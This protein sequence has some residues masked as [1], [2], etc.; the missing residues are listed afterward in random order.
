MVTLRNYL[1]F[2]S[3][4]LVGCSSPQYPKYSSEQ[5][6]SRN[7]SGL[8]S[9][10]ENLRYLFREGQLPTKRKDALAAGVDRD[11]VLGHH[12]EG[13]FTVGRNVNHYSALLRNSGSGSTGSFKPFFE[14]LYVKPDTHWLDAGGGEGYATKMAIDLPDSK[15][16]TTLISVE[17]NAEDIIDGDVL[18]R[19]VFK[20]RF[21][22]DIGD[23]ELAASDLV[24]DVYGPIAYSSRPDIV[25]EKYLHNLKNDGV[26]YL[27]LGEE[28]DMF[29]KYNQIITSRGEVLDF[30]DWLK[31]INGTE[32][33]I[34]TTR[35][36]P[37][38]S[39]VLSGEK[40]RTARMH[41]D[42]SEIQ[43]PKL[44][45]IG[46]KEGSGV[47]GF[48]VP[49]TVFVEEGESS[50]LIYP[51]NH[52]MIPDIEGILKQ[53]NR[54]NGSNTL[55][56]EVDRLKSSES[57]ANF[58]GFEL[59]FK[60]FEESHLTRLSDKNKAKVVKLATNDFRAGVT[61]LGELNG[62]KNLKLIT[63]LNGSF[64]SEET[65]DVVLKQYI[66]ALDDDGVIILGLGRQFGGLGE[67]QVIDH[68][69]NSSLLRYWME[70]IEGLNVKIASFQQTEVVTGK[71]LNVSPDAIE[72]NYDGPLVEF[73]EEQSFFSEY[74]VLKIKN[75]NKVK[76]PK[77]EYLG[78]KP[79]NE[80]G[81]EMPFYRQIQE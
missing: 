7:P 17:T 67:G 81:I 72:V 31:T 27:H 8:F 19:K 68:V 35:L 28:K 45:R 77:L 3:I 42:G 55:I 71:K 30:S 69:E 21:I 61:S 62:Q 53:F 40:G 16:N 59:D 74:I 54:G 76:I 47:N 12:K 37:G 56:E 48:V 23:E 25:L 13:S 4:I 22:E 57:W 20:G 24:T 44:Q 29:G 33:D 63:D 79:A 78:R 58:S 73:K 75:R 39:V 70:K 65:P 1:T 9:C 51:R 80:Y 14:A 18:R 6:I 11:Y 41:L 52:Q 43:V 49:R 36:F 15:I 60:N 50:S 26:V 2:L 66:D 34:M 46:F 32:T 38:D 5:S 10:F 64:L